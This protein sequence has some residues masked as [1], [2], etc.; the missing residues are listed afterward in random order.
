MRQRADSIGH[1]EKESG[2][3]TCGRVCFFALRLWPFALLLLLAPVAAQTV[4]DV[5]ITNRATYTYGAA[6]HGAASGTRFTGISTVVDLTDPRGRVRD[7]YGETL[8]DY[9]GFSVGLFSPEPAD[10]DGS[11]VREVVSLTGTEWPDVPGNSVPGGVQP[12]TA[13]VNPFPLTDADQGTYCFLLDSAREQLQQNRAYV[14]VVNPPPGSDYMQRRIRIVAGARNGDQFTYTATALDAARI[15][16]ADAGSG[17]TR[18]TMV[19]KGAAPGQ[20]YAVISLDIHVCRPQ[21]IEISKTGDRAAAEPG[22]TVVYRVTVKNP[23]ERPLHTVR[24]TDQ[25][26]VGFHLERRSVR[27]ELDGERVPIRTTVR[28]RT[29]TFAAEG[30]ALPPGGELSLIYATLVTPEA[31]RGRGINVATVIAI[32]TMAGNGPPASETVSAGP[33]RYRVRLLQGLL[34][35]TGTIIGRVFVDRNFDGEQQA[36]EPGVPDAVILLD[37]GTRIVTDADGLFS[38]A[39]VVSGYRTAVLDYLSIPGYR[40]APNR[41]F[42]GR[43]SPSRMAHL[44]PGGL[45]RMNFGITPLPDGEGKQ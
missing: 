31:L 26:P 34:T 5:T 19:T 4:R 29:V 43:S 22:D 23:G 37:D 11:E 32:L 27:G 13:N 39:N 9:R 45:V 14:L 36:G 18:I 1:G 12:N 41:R 21:N 44:E 42:R 6:E 17:V 15:N 20:V 25:L 28:G 10:P 3:R 24:V 40:I 2:A 38:V 33:V 7:C 35:D 16:F 8:A 30:L